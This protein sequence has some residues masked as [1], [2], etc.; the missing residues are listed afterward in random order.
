MKKLLILCI[1]ACSFCWSQ[2]DDSQ[3]AS[4]NVMGAEYPR[5]HSD[6]SVT[7]RL[8]APDAKKV[9]VDIGQPYD[10]TRA[11][12]GTWSVTVPP[13][14][15]GFHYYSLVIDGVQVCDPAS[16]TFFGMGRQASGIE[17]P[18]KGVDYYNVQNVPHG[19]VRSLR[20][21][22]KYANSWRRAFVYTPP[23]YA[24]NVKARYP[25]LYL[26]HGG[27]EDERGWV[28]QGYM[29]NIMDNL[30]AAGKAVPMIVVMENS[31]LGKP[32]ERMP[33]PPRLPPDPS[34]PM[35]ITVP[36]T[37]GEIM[38]TDL[39]PLIDSRYRTIADREHRAIA[40]LSFGAAYALQI[41]L[42]S[43]EK[44]AWFGSFSGTVLASLDA[45]T[46]YGGVLSNG[47]EFNKKARLMFIAAGTAE[48]SRLK[49][50]Q[51]ARDEF[52]KVGIH[53]VF[54]ASPGTAHEWLTWRRDLHEFAPLLFQKK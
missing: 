45:T 26:Q 27:G 41:G 38:M 16:E 43:L 6:L 30:I 40:G 13:Q 8:K 18:E 32:G 22:S 9:Q 15:P 36:P 51:H 28:T 17:I 14:V 7:F 44:F 23:D 24:T 11:E 48:E 2:A 10:M 20:Y 37:F 50:A 31:S 54:Y 52:E 19:A 29:D 49:A 4:T 25:V 33:S 34:R 5:V 21:F 12:D 3:P 46:S 47:A 1:L 35:V 42:T 39:V 53:Y